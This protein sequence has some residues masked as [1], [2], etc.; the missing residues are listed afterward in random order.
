MPFDIKGTLWALAICLL[1]LVVIFRG[2]GKRMDKFREHRDERRQE[3]QQRFDERREQRFEWRE[4]RHFDR[5]QRRRIF[6]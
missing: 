3:R 1:L 2:C 5:K 4:R 6:R